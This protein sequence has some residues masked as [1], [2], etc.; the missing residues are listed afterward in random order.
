MMVS[1]MQHFKN[2]TKLYRLDWKR[3]FSNPMTTFLV[4]ALMFLPSLYAWF[5]IKAL[6]D[7][8]GNTKEIPIAVF[9]SDTGTDFNGKKINVGDEVIENLQKNE[10]LGWRFVKSEKVLKEGVQSGKFYAGIYLPTNFSEDLLSFTSGEIQKPT[11]DYYFNEKINAIA[12][13]ITDKGA[14]SLQDQI[15]ENFINTASS[16]LLEVFNLVGYEVE[17]NLVSINKVKNLI[18]EMDQNSDNIEGYTQEIL[19]L[20]EKLPD[21]KNKLNKAEEFT[22]YLPEVDQMAEKLVVLNQKMPQI[23]EE[24]KIILTLQDKIPEIQNAGKQLAMVDEDFDQVSTTL[25][26]GIA[27]ANQ[28]LMI[29]QEVESLLPKIVELR[30]NASDFTDQTIAA[31]EKLDTHLDEITQTVQINLNMVT[32]LAETINH[33]AVTLNSLLSQTED[34]TPEQ[35]AIIKQTLLGIADVLAKQQAMIS[36][37][38]DW[39]QQLQQQL[40]GDFSEIIQHLNQVNELLAVTSQSATQLAEITDSISK[41]ELQQFLNDLQS[42]TE[43]LASLG[44]SI[45]VEAVSR[46]VHVLLENKLLPALENTQELLEASKNVDLEALLQATEKTV[47]NAV[48]ILEKYQEELPAIGKEIHD[49]NLLLN[50]HMDQI[51]N[52]INKGVSL[53]NEELPELQEKLAKAADFVTNEYPTVKSEVV[54]TLEMVDEKFPK[55][56]TALNTASQLIEED[57]PSM[58]R[59]IHK[60]AMA[61]H[62]GEEFA[63]LNDIISL[64]KNDVQAESDFFTQPVELNTTAMYPMENN[65]SASTPFYTALCLWVGALLLS[66]VAATDFHLDKKDRQ[67]FSQR[68]MFLARMGTF[69]TIGLAQSLIVT[70]GNYFVLGVD[71]RNPVYSILFALLVG[72]VFMTMIYVFASLFGNLGKGIGIILLVLSISGGGGNYPIQVSGKFFQFI[73][74]LLPFTYAVDL[75]RESAGGIYWPNAIRNASVLLILGLI[76][77]IVGTLVSPLMEKPLKKMNALTKESHFFH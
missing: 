16:T 23:T 60:A 48:T 35:R 70:L 63:D 13:K 32:S 1:E 25:T 57:W 64:L 6:W 45:D 73:N 72:W 12:P 36:D 4:I 47:S 66:S 39:F 29:M 46:Q 38:I 28:A 74:P 34:W 18:L 14:S 69:L 33:Y 77:G 27:E 67:R 26:E 51:V 43:R 3:I 62:K 50:G 65:G 31:G 56:E 22:E 52:G 54:T 11:I 9:S 19:A 10:Q 7:P 20:H 76:F 2:I 15:T 41:T 59:G 42:L 44:N 75:L 55:V 53:Y 71:V 17:S 61:I 24:A 40:G 68:E 5:N 21:I 30:D 49:A 58:K 8:Y 37:L